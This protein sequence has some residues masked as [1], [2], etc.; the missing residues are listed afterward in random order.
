LEKHFGPD[1]NSSI[2]RFF[3][4]K[5]SNLILKSVISFALANKRA[6]INGDTSSNN[7]LP[8]VFESFKKKTPQSSMIN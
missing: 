8:S 5:I 3:Q 1:I 2:T 7:A 4:T 6:K